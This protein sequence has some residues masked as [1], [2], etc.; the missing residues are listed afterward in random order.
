M[1]SYDDGE[2]FPAPLWSML[3]FDF[4]IYDEHA[5]MAALCNG[6]RVIVHLSGDNFASPS[7]KEKYSFFLQVAENFELED[8][9]VE[10]FYDWI[11]EPLLP[12]FEKLSELD[13]LPST[14]DAFLFPPT[15]FFTLQSD[16]EIIVAVPATNDDANHPLF[17]VNLPESHCSPWPSF[18]P[19]EIQILP[20]EHHR[21][22]PSPIPSKVEMQN[23]QAAFLKMMRPGERG[24]YMSELDTY[25]QIR[26]APLDANLQ[27]PRLHGIVRDDNG[28]SYG[29]LLTYIDCGRRT[30]FCAA[31]KAR[32]DAQLVR[33]WSA[34]IDE[35][36]GQLH[37]AEIAWGDAK[38]DNILI[39]RNTESIW[40]IDFGGSY[41][42]GWVPKELAGTIE[43]DLVGLSKIKKF[44]ETGEDY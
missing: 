12:F 29:F 3:E 26:D 36:L 40:L 25:K 38:P 19:S 2:D 1:D 34:Q 32:G 33:Q 5:K 20:E 9:T 21:G 43:G 27:I 11:A 31:S 18:K 6:R 13:K 24:S 35:I 41:T 7:H 37:K 30:L 23:G 39:D 42:E 16:G 44:L 14:L 28:T 4:N 22:P 10:D 17:G 15:H 8:Y